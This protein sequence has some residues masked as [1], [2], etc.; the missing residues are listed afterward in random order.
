MEELGL[1]IFNVGSLQSPYEVGHVDT[2]GDARAVATDGTY[3]YVADWRSGLQVID[4]SDPSTPVLVGSCDT[5]DISDGVCYRD[6]LVYLA[7]HAGGLKVF[8]V[9]DPAEPVLVGSLDT[10]YANSVFA[11]DDFVF[12]ADRDWGLVVVDEE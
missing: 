5:D 2:P 12:V 11:T 4:I 8:D 6:G 3:A 9:G 1:A 7:D 10:P